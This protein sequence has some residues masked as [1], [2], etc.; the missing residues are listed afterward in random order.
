[1]RTSTL[2]TS[3]LAAVITGAA[4]SAQLTDDQ[5]AKKLIAGSIAEYPGA[6]PCP[7]NTA[8]NGSSCGKRSAWSKPGGHSPLCYRGDVTD[9]MI[10]QYRRQQRE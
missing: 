9:E 2:V 5:I 10:R 4:A 1:M 8:R 6:C 7:Y 3:L